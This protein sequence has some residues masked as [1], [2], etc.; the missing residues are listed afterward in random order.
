MNEAQRSLFESAVIERLKES[1]FLEI[2]IRVECL[3]RCDDGYQDEVINAGWHYWNA[4][5]AAQPT[6]SPQHISVGAHRVG[7]RLL[8]GYLNAVAMLGYGDKSSVLELIAD[9]R[10]AFGPDAAP[11]KERPAP[12]E[13][14][15][16]IEEA[17]SVAIEPIIR[18][19]PMGNWR[20]HQV[21][22]AVRNAV[23]AARAEIERLESLHRSEIADMAERFRSVNVS[24]AV[25]QLAD[26]LPAPAG[27][28]INAATDV[29]ASASDTYKKRNGH[30]GSFEDDS[31]EKCWIVPFDAFEG[32]RS[33][34][35]A[36]SASEVEG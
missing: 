6:P 14:V 2:E 31:G 19:Y 5:I 10:Q 13:R 22:E 23:V 25:K 30:L 1:G 8:N 20:D 21:K 27:R 33:A 17:V 26:I 12:A 9:A 11:P 28:L 15:V 34:V 29:I 7:A 4:A 36:L 32:L 18:Q 24:E 35:A 3:V 16:G